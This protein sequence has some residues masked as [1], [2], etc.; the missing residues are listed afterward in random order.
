MFLI[1]SF[2]LSRAGLGRK[3]GR[4]RNFGLSFLFAARTKI[5]L[6]WSL[7]FSLFC[8]VLFN[9]RREVAFF[10]LDYAAFVRL[11]LPFL[12]ST[13]WQLGLEEHR[14]VLFVGSMQQHFRSRVPG[15][16]PGPGPG[17]PQPRNPN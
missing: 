2:L 17:H 3:E 9:G 11:P 7:A 5:D 10:C 15:L 1:L 8:L 12:L 16:C 14:A 13:V 6:G 4:E